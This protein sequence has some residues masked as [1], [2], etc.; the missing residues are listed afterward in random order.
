MY[1]TWM[2][3]IG[4]NSNNNR[5]TRRVTVAGTAGFCFGVDRAVKLVESLLDSG[6]R[7]CTLGPI[8]HNPSV[9]E[10]FSRRGVVIVESVDEVPCD[11]VLVIRSHGVEKSVY[12]RLAELG[13]EYADATCPFVSKIHRIVADAAAKNS[14]VL[15]AG[16][17]HHPEVLGIA[18]HCVKPDGTPG[19][20]IVFN[21][22]TTLDDI[23][24][25]LNAENSEQIVT[26]VAQTTFNSELWK[27]ASEKIKKGFAIAEIYGTICNAT[28]ERQEEAVELSSKCDL[29]I[30]IGGRKSS[31]TAKLYH[32]CAER[33]PAVLVESAAELDPDN[34]RDAFDIGITAG[35][36]T[37]ADIIK[38]VE[39]TMSEIINGENFAA[40]LEESF[41]NSNS[42]GKVVEG[43]VVRIAPTEIYVD[44]GRKQSGVVELAELTDNPNLTPADC[45][46]VG[47][48]LELMILRTNDQ[49]GYIYLSKRIL[50]SSR[51]WDEI[52]AAAPKIVNR[53]RRRDDDENEDVFHA[54]DETEN[55]A[56]EV[57]ETVEEQD[58]EPIV[59]TGYV[60][61]VVKGGIIASYKGVKV[62]I[63][64]SQATANRNDPLEDLV[65]KEVKFVIL[66]VNPGRRR[67]VGSIRAVLSKERKALE[68]AFWENIEEGQVFTGTVKSLT[69]YGA[70]VGL[71]A[72][73]GMIHI[74]E[75][76]WNR[77]KHPSEVV[78]VGDVVEVYVKKLDKEKKKI[79][80]GY[81]KTED[82]PWEILKANYPVGTVIEAPVVGTPSFGAFVRILPGI[83][84]LVHISQLSTS[85]VNAPTDVVKEGDLVRAVIT[86][87]DLEK[88][89]ISL[90][91]RR[92]LEAEAEAAAE[93]EADEDADEADGNVINVVTA[94]DAPAAE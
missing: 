45:V 91:I 83:D 41:K 24:K 50:D 71:G 72:V 34:Y 28:R 32:I 10:D 93:A 8:I 59:F 14:T 48:K 42:N 37:P 20:C 84:G 64:A 90:S 87:V 25:K 61:E 19:R 88:K 33:C 86:E 74:S 1:M 58:V 92:L 27:L 62:F 38:E 15:I 16:D 6:R 44:V 4:M 75:L 52:K 43:T 54:D 7:V 78:N 3:K 5:R 46:K 40:L 56:P 68:Q 26:A 55:A 39:A 73:D 30:V 69:A 17:E 79:S 11:A 82:N 13:V 89:R 47:D 12:D 29:M 9:I 63:P 81:K 76:S 70:F 66:E 85:H 21:D 57:V 31:N 35:A 36:S 80:L 49:E 65:K 53:S 94:D 22:I 60:T 23:I 51:A 18:G 67:A 77:I 2:E